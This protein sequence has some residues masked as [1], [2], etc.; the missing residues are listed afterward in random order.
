[1]HFKIEKLYLR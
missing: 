1:M